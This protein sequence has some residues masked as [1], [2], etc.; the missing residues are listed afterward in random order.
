MSIAN[1]PEIQLGI[2]YMISLIIDFLL[3]PK[4][5]SIFDLNF[6]LRVFVDYGQVSVG[7][8][9]EIN[10]IKRIINITA[11]YFYNVL[12][13]TRLPRLYYPSNVSLTCNT[14]TVDPVYVT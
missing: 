11:N 2:S 12:N 4:L 9:V 10:T 1:S 8:D 13:V 7:T 14:L 5:A 3:L 6:R